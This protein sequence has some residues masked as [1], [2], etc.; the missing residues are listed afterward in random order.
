[1]TPRSWGTAKNVPGLL[2]LNKPPGDQD[3]IQTVSCAAPGHC[4]A[5]GYYSDKPVVYND[6]FVVSEP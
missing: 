1:M 6:P 3:F 4:S 5:G 2:A